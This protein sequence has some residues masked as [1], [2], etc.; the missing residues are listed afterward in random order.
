MLGRNSA[1]AVPFVLLAAVA[2]AGAQST[3]QATRN[4]RLATHPL[5]ISRGVFKIS[6][7]GMPKGMDWAI[8]V[9]V[10]PGHAASGQF[11]FVHFFDNS[12][13]PIP[14]PQAEENLPAKALKISPGSIVLRDLRK[15]TGQ[16]LC[17]YIVLPQPTAFRVEVNGR[18]LA[19]IPHSTGFTIHNGR[20]L[21]E[22]PR[23]FFSVMNLLSGF[24]AS[25]GTQV[26]SSSFR[27]I[28]H[29]FVLSG[30]IL[31]IS[32]EA[33][34]KGMDWAVGVKVERGHKPSAQFGLLRF[35]TRS[36][37]VGLLVPQAGESLPE[38]SLKISPGSIVL[39]NLGTYAGQKL[40]GYLILSRPIAVG[41]KVNGAGIV[42]VHPSP[43][44]MIH[45]GNMLKEAPSSPLAV[46]NLLSDLGS[47]T[48]S[49]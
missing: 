44:F 8:G 2:I 45:D 22:A 33:L 30:G 47:A 27:F 36:G 29:P 49:R 20:I 42:E 16:K 23:S 35:S 14:L 19:E 46:M 12:L 28:P 43:G 31:T 9:K 40:Y 41:V 39:K 38:S 21:K 34:P 17:G 11:A 25:P 7:D 37:P 4:F 5:S 1:V 13:G 6:V 10:Q 18:L 3:S 32:L 15:Y 24:H 48:S 26:E